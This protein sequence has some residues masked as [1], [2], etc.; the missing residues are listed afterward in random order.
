MNDADNIDTSA[1]AHFVDEAP[2]PQVARVQ[3]V[4]AWATEKKLLPAFFPPP[5]FRAPK[6][7]AGPGGFAR[8]V[9]SGLSGPVPN[10][11]AWKFAVARIG[12]LWPEGKEMTEAEFDAAVEKHT[13]HVCR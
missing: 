3:T 10:R 5:A 4:E 12:E 6:G 7:A 8:V 2:A 13:N 1:E 11:H 9:M